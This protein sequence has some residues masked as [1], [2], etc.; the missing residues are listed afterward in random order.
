V[1]GLVLSLLLGGTVYLV[2]RGP[3]HATLPADRPSGGP[4]GREQDEADLRADAAAGLLE[5]LAERLEHGTREQVVALAAPGQRAAAQELTT[6]RSNVRALGVTN[7]S[8]RYVDEDGG[9]VDPTQQR[10]LGGRAWVGNVQV[11][12]RL[13]GFDRADS[14]MET[15][16]T[17]VRSGSR[18]AFVSARGNYGNATPLWMLERVSVAR[19]RRSLVL[20]SRDRPGRF[21]GLADQAVADVRK[22]LPAWRGGLV[23]EVPAGEAQ[24]SRVLGSELDAYD[25]IAAVTTTADG[26]RA[27]NAPVHVFV[28]PTVFDPLGPRGSQIV[29]SHE[30][31]HVAT[32]AATSQMPTWLLEGFADYVALADVDLPVTRTASQ[33][34]DQV[35]R[36]GPPSHL[37]GRAEFDP[38]NTALG[39]SYEAA[40]LACRLLAEEYGQRRLIQF[41]RLS[42]RLSSTTRPFRS[43]LHT[44]QRRFTRAWMRYLR[45]LAP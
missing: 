43:V 18:A 39:A 26:S 9:R 7:L 28:N 13:R 33:I 29:M 41:Y 15:T 4:G 31:T 40:W 44:D 21:A 27:P 30:A 12:W 37:P 36:K 16:L 24:L 6:I 20:S 17:L 8:L 22:V 35:S 32:G 11:R 38:E 2:V 3:D 1:A 23:V 19:T 45:Q 42:D 14:R 34:L 25:G 10:A 5:R